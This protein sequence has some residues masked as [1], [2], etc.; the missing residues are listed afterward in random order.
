MVFIN[1]G[2]CCLREQSEKYKRD[3]INHRSISRV[4]FKRMRPNL[5]PTDNLILDIDD[6]TNVFRKIFYI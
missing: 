6:D 2:V 1:L 5:I 3:S 4:H